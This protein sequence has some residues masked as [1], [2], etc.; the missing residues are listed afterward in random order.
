MLVSD[1]FAV[2]NH[3]MSQMQDF[4]LQTLAMP[5]HLY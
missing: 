4:Q 3:Y 1:P 2:L 5:Q